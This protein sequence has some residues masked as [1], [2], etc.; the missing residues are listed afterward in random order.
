MMFS[1]TR[2]VY[3]CLP[4][5]KRRFTLKK[6]M[7]FRSLTVA[8]R[9]FALF[10]LLNSTVQHFTVRYRIVWGFD[11]QATP[12]HPHHQDDEIRTITPV[13]DN[14]LLLQRSTQQVYRN[15][16]KSQQS[17]RQNLMAFKFLTSTQLEQFF[18]ERV[19][20]TKLI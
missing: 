14:V 10:L 6:C 15:L 12:P 5:G 18:I 13:F 17:K 7:W 4:S 2:A 1:I 9:M 20:R 8:S 11:S 19:D 3:R 16:W